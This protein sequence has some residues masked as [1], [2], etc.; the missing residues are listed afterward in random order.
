MLQLGTVRPT[1]SLPQANQSEQRGWGALKTQ[2]LKHLI[3]Q[4]LKA[5]ERSTCHVVELLKVL[6]S[7]CHHVF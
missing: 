4:K 7:R 1:G 3:K 5:T 6:P 2:R